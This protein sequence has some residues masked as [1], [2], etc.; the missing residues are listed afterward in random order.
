MMDGIE[1]AANYKAMYHMDPIQKKRYMF[2]ISFAFPTCQF[3]ECVGE[4][5]F[6]IVDDYH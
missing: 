1:L 4:N 5:A 3:P 6:G 2:W